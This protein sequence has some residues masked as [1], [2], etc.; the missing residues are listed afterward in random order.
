MHKIFYGDRPE[1]FLLTVI[2]AKFPIIMADI[3][4]FRI[5]ALPVKNVCVHEGDHDDVD[6]DCYLKNSNNSDLDRLVHNCTIFLC[7]LDVRNR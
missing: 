7:S 5:L 1:E 6:D 2:L 3:A 4:I